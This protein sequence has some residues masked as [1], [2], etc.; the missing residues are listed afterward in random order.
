MSYKNLN[1]E[2]CYETSSESTKLIDSFYIPMLSETTKYLRIAG[3]FSSSSLAIAAK[4]IAGLIN[5]GGVM[6]LLI[7]PE[8]SDEDFEIIKLFHDKKLDQNSLLFK[9]FD[10]ADFSSNEHL[11]A[12]AWM[13]ANGKLEIKIVVGKNSGTSLFHQ[14]VGIGFDSEGNML[15]FSGSI[16]ETAKAWID[17]IEEFK[18]FKSWE[19]EQIDYLLSDLKKFNSYWNNERKDISDVYDLP[20]SICQKIISVKPKDIFDLSIMKKY[21][22]KKEEHSLLS[23]FQHQ[24]NGVR[25][26]VNNGFSL[27]FEMATGTGKTRTAIGCFTELRKT[28]KNLLVIVA[29]PQNTLSRQWKADIDGLNIVFNYSK[30]IDGSNPKWKSDFE[31]LLLNLQSGMIDDAIIYTT[32]DTASSSS[33]LSIIKNNKKSIKILFICDECH[34]IGSEH[35]KQALLDEYEYRIGLSATPDRMFDE[36][37][38]SFIKNYFGNKS[39]E[40]SIYDALHTIN[41]ITNKPFLNP[42]Y[43]YPRFVDLNDEEQC[44]YNEFSKKIAFAMSEEEPDMEV[45]NLLR[46]KRAEILKNATLKM[47]EVETI[48]D[49]LS[50]KKRIKDTIIFSTDRQIDDVLL[51]LSRKNITR[52]K[53]TEHESASKITGVNGLT[54]REENIEQFRRGNIQCLVGIKCLDEGIDIKNA[55]VAILMASSTN[56]REYVQRVGRVI[57]PDKG[58]EYSIIYDLIVK[59]SDESFDSSVS[60]LQ[61]EARRALMIASNAVNAAEV[62]NIFEESGVD[63]K[64]LLVEK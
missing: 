39:F 61:K 8:I 24:E 2:K 35:Q 13:L 57:R 32:H 27:L 4:G 62:I 58:K 59:P 7:S 33:F 38:T 16:N 11:Q 51:M 1:I 25:E 17:N 50:E 36:S 6:K 12:L 52:S 21:A 28:E 47:E 23:L 14:K 29:T 26:W 64:C 34:A 55:R 54:E 46:T 41:P 60:I 19:P 56:P 49:E 22:K 37:G 15:S 48:I 42:F 40:F 43:Y 44:R 10:I 53:I 30:I 45:V 63:T 3:F 18:T 5:N 31:M 20:D 9:D